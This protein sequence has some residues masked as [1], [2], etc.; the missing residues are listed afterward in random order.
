MYFHTW[1]TWD[2]QNWFPSASGGIFDKNKLFF[3][4]WSLFG[5]RVVG[6]V[7]V[8]KKI[9]TFG[10]TFTPP[11]TLRPNLFKNIKK[12]Y[13]CQIYPLILGN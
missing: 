2:H 7:K 4:F 3:Y 6:G 10:V 8:G 11:T 13:F 12:V 5:I 9:W 1:E